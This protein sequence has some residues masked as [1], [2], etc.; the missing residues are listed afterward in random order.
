MRFIKKNF[1]FEFVYHIIFFYPVS[2]NL[3]YF[4]NFGI[5]ALVILGIQ[6]ITG[7]GLAMHYIP[8]VML[9]FDSIEHIMRDVNYGWLLRYI[10]SNGASFFFFTVYIHIFR[11]LYYGSFLYPREFLWCVGVII[12]LLM[13]LTAFLGYVL[14]WGQMSFWAA[15][16]IT[17]LASVVPFVGIEIVQWIWGGYAVDNATLNR[18]FS[19]HLLFPFL[20]LG[21]VII[22]IILLHIVKSNNV[23]SINSIDNIY[24][25]PYYTIK[26]LYSLIVL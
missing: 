20:I 3:S 25:T 6:I 23:L 8:N 18:F 10:H 12:F 4:W 17:N 15:T 26:D 9:A 21:L 13:I 5:F 2:S 19:L 24:F 11:G 22:H 1:L 7:I 16:V 14:P